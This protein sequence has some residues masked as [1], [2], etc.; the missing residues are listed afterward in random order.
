MAK[1][2]DILK[3]YGIYSSTQ[4]DEDEE[5][6]NSKA[7]SVL[8]KYG[9]DSRPASG[10]DKSAGN[11]ILKKYGLTPIR[12]TGIRNPTP[13]QS[14]RNALIDY[15]IQTDSMNR[16]I[17]Q[18][19]YDPNDNTMRY[20]RNQAKRAPSDVDQYIQALTAA[21]VGSDSPY[22]Q[23]LEAIKQNYANVGSYLDEQYRQTDEYKMLN[24]DLEAGQKEIDRLKQKEAERNSLRSQLNFLQA[25]G[26]SAGSYAA[27][28]GMYTDD[29]RK[30]E[31]ER[32]QGELA[33]YANV[34]TE[35][36]Q[37]QSMKYY[38]ENFRKYN[39]V[40]NRDD[41]SE[42]S[43][44]KP[45]G[46]NG[47]WNQA[48]N[49]SD[50]ATKTYELI[51]NMDDA[52]SSLGN[53]FYSLDQVSGYHYDLMEPEERKMFNYL[54]NTQGK[55]AASE[56]LDYI[57]FELNRRNM[58]NIADQE[59][60]YAQQ[61]FG[62]GLLASI[63]SV[64]NSL[65]GGLGA[66]DVTLQ[67]IQRD[68]TG[69]YKPIDYNT[70]AMVPS[71]KAA[72]ARQ[73]V[74]ESITNATGVIQISEEEHPILA[75]VLNGKS[76]ADVYNLGMS[77]A[78]SAAAAL[79]TKGLGAIGVPQKLASGLGSSLL[80]GNAASQGMIEAI[81]NGA[82]D[83]QALQLGLMNGLYESLFEAVSID[84]LT[85]DTATGFFKTMLKQGGIEASEEA[86]TT[87][88]NTFAD[89]AIM[90]ENSDY[91]KNISAYMEQGMTREEAEKQAFLDSVIQVGW[92]A[93]GG[94]LSGGVSAG[95]KY[96]IGSAIQNIKTNEQNKAFYGD[97]TGSIISDA[98]EL[99]PENKFVQ[100]MQQKQADGKELSGREITRLM[101]ENQKA[102]YN[103]EAGEV[104]AAAVDS[105]N[106]LGETGD[107]EAIA[108]AITKQVT[109]KKL[110]M[111][112]K[113]AIS[114]SQFGSR[115][116]SELS[117]Y[118]FSPTNYYADI[119]ERIANGSLN[120]DN[121]QKAEINQKDA[122][123]V[124]T[125]S[126]NSAQFTMVNPDTVAD[127]S[128]S[129]PGSIQNL[130]Q[131]SDKPVSIDEVAQKYGAQSNYVKK[132]YNIGSN[133]D[134]KQ[135]DSAFERVFNY[136]QSGTVRLDVVKNLESIRS[137]LTDKQIELAYETGTAAANTAAKNLE[138]NNLAQANGKNGRKIGVVKGEGVS[139]EDLKKTFNDNQN[140]A[141][142]I[143]STY[144]EAT[145]IDIVLYQSEMDANGNFQG[146]Q[147]R[148]NRG[149]PGT[150][151]IDINAGL[152]G[153]HDVGNLAK[154]TMLR[155][156]AHEFTHFI[157]KWNPVQY[158]EF[159]KV[160]FDTLRERGENVDDLVEA[161]QAAGLSYDMASREVVAEAMTDIL[162]DSHFVQNLAEKHK[163]IFQK[164]MEKLKEF[165]ESLRSYFDSLGKNR[166]REAN[167]LKEQVGETVRYVENIVKMFD[168]VAEQAVENYQL[169]VAVDE[170]TG[171]I[172]IE[173]KPVAE[174]AE[175]NDT[176]TEDPVVP[177]TQ[178]LESSAAPVA[179]TENTEVKTA[180]RRSSGSKKKT[181]LT[182][183]LQFVKKASDERLRGAYTAQDGK[184]Y[185]TDGSFAAVF[186]SADST[187]DHKVDFP[188]DVVT[189]FFSAA[190]KQQN[191][192]N[193]RIDDSEIRTLNRTATKK[194]M[195][196]V[197]VGPSFF[198]VKYVYA[199]SRAF[200]N[201]V[202]SLYRK[203]NLSSDI[204]I[205]RVSADNGEAILMPVLAPGNTQAAYEAKLSTPHESEP[206]ENLD[207]SPVSQKEDAIDETTAVAQ[208]APETSTADEL[209]ETKV[210]EEYTEPQISNIEKN[211]ATKKSTA[212]HT[213]ETSVKLEDFGEKI[214][215]ARKDSWSGRG[216]ILDDLS[217]MNDRERSNAVKKDNVWRRPDYR[218]LVEGGESKALLFARNEIRKTL[219]QNITYPRVPED[220]K[221]SPQY[222]EKA[223]KLQEDF[224]RTV[225]EIQK[226]A[227][228]AKTAEDFMN[229]GRKWLRENGYITSVGNRDQYTEK[230]RSNPALRGSDYATTVE[231]LSRNFDMLDKL[232]EKKGFAAD[233]KTQVPKGFSI[234]QDSQKNGTWFAAKGRYIIRDNFQTYDDALNFL[235]Q[236]TA[237]KKRKTRFVPNQLL[238]VHRK[239]PD[240]R[241][242]QDVTGQDY[243][244][245]FG[246]RGGEFGNWMSEKDRRVSMNYGF[247]AL[248][249]LADALQIADADI[250]LGGN[251]SIAF[252]SRGQGLSGAAAHYEPDR[253]VINLTKMNGA[254]SLAH[255]WFHALDD[256]V[257][258]YRNNFAT[259]FQRG[260]PE[261]TSQAIRHLITTMQYRDATQAETD[262]EASKRYEQARR[263]V[264]YNITSMF[265]WVEKM[266]AGTLTEGETKYFKKKPTA[267]DA[268][269]FHDALNRLLDSGDAKI[270]EELSDLRKE[271][272]G[273]VIPK[274]IRDSIGYRLY[275]LR[276]DATKNIQRA[277]VFSDFYRNSRKFNE[278][279]QKDGDYWDST[280]EM[281]ARAFACYIADKTGARNDYLSAHSD[282]AVG[283]DVNKSGE[284]TV[285]KA[286]PEGQERIAINA[287]FDSLFAA[288][289]DDG[290]LHRQEDIEKPGVVQYQ[291]RHL[292]GKS[293]Q[294]QRRDY[295]KYSY[296]WFAAK[297]DMPMTVV[298][299]NFPNNH[300]AVVQKAKDNAATIG[301]VNPKDRSV[302]VYVDDIGTNIVLG[303]KGL[304]HGLDR[305]F[306]LLAPITVKAGEIIKNSIL[307]NEITPRDNGAMEGYVLIGIAKASNGQIYIVRSV[308]NR[309][310]NELA[311]MDV[312]YAINAKK[313][314][315]GRLSPQGG[316]HKSSN[317]SGSK[318]SIASLLSIVNQHFP[319]V[320]PEDVLKH[321]G[322]D[323]RPDGTFS[324]D[325]L[326]QQRTSPLTDRDVLEAA[327]ND[328]GISDMSDA[329]QAALQTFK[330][331]LAELH[332]LQEKRA[333]A[334]RLYKEQQ[335]GANVDRQ[336]AAQTLERMRALDDQ[337]KTASVAVLDVEQKSVLQRVL[338]KA[339]KVV[340]QQERDRS[341]AVLKRWRDR[342]DNADAVKKY[343]TRVE[344]SS[345][346]LIDM[347]SHPTKD[348]HVPYELQAPL[349]E[350]L[351][352]IDF[353]SKTQNRG[354]AP[355]I[356]DRAYTSALHSMRLAI[357]GQ[358]TAIEG[359]ENGAYS[360]DV[361]PEFLNVIDEH[362][363]KINQSVKS[364]Q[365]GTSRVYDMTSSELADLA[366]LLGTINK[367]IR[368]ID[369]LHMAGSKA[370]ISELAV[371]TMQEMRS[372]K[373]VKGDS[374]N[375][376]I[377]ANYTPW[378][379]FRAMGKD[380]QQIFKG[381]MQ[382]QAK[383]ARTSH[384]TIAFTEKTYKP[385]EA[386]NW[387][388]KIHTIELSSGE[389]I[390]MTTAQ[391]MSFWCLSNR[392]QGVG[393]LTGGGIRIGTIRDENFR[394]AAQ[395]QRDIVQ[396]EH[397]VLTLDDIAA[398]N[399]LL[400]DRQRTVAR[401]LQQYMQNVGG[402]LGNEISMA[403]WDFMQFTEDGYFPIQT[404][405]AT[406]DVKNPGQDKTN[407]WALLN[408]SFT[409]SLTPNAKNAVI[410]NSIFDVFA[411]HMTEM[412][413][414]NAFALPL[415]DAMKWFNY[416][417]RQ[418]LG[419]GQIADV[420]V[421]KSI[422][423]TLGTAAVKYFVDLMT[424]LNSSQKAGRHENILGQILSRTK[425]ASV[426]W[427]L[428]VAV[429]QPT[430]ILRASMFLSMPDLLK[431]SMRIGAS[432]SVKEMQQYSGIALWKS[433][434]FYDVNV[435]R[436]VREQI[437]GNENILDKF[438]S[439]GM[440]LPGKM[441]EFT[442]ARIWEA[443]K[444]KV[445]R[446]QHFTGEPLLKATAELFEDI[447]Y[448]SQVA[449]S[450]L[451]RSSFMRSKSQ[452]MREATSFMS[453]PTL[454]SNI[455]ISAFQDFEAGHT[456]WDKAKRA[457]VIGFE[458]Y[459]L[460]GVVNAMVTALM[461]AWRDDDKYETF[462][463]KYVQ[464]L[465][466]EN[467][468][469]DGNLFAEM[470]PLEKIIFVRDALSIIRGYDVMPGYADLFKQGYDFLTSAKDFFTDRGSMTLYGLI[471]RGLQVLGTT[472]GIA[473][474]GLSREAIALH[475]NVVLP[476][477]NKTFGQMYP[478]MELSPIRRYEPSGNTEIKNAFLR[479]YLTEEEAIS[480]LV[481]QGLSDT[482]NDAYFL[483][484]GWA[485]EEEDYTRY[486]KVFDA[487]RNNGDFNAALNDMV[488]HGYERD[489]VIR[490][491]R[492]QIGQWYQGGEI[493]K[494]QA[495][496]MLKKHVGLDN[497][498]VTE[499][500]NRWSSYVVTGIKFDDIKQAYLDG[501]ITLNRAI[502]MYALYGSHTKERATEIVSK[503]GSIKE[504]GYEIDE[505]D[506]AYFDGE[507]GLS[508]V[509]SMYIKYGGY[510]AEEA[511]EKT[512]VLEFVKQN[513]ACDGISYAAVSGYN[514][515]CK[516]TGVNP[517]TFYD[518]WKFKNDAGSDY[519]VDGEVTV[520]KKEKVMDYIDGLNLTKSQKDSLYYACG[521]AESTLNETPWH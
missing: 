178:E 292:S 82:T 300:K 338:K 8:E 335:F 74:G 330:D 364:Y 451:T 247:D 494:S 132:I 283:F 205:L 61:N 374:G 304:R 94:F 467:S 57:Q 398:I 504:T 92:D 89:I 383:L 116:A 424:D 459:V 352:S 163:N 140:I 189:S 213:V 473:F 468:I 298:D 203:N 11:D 362:I 108:D 185:L 419:D 358:R 134:V 518:V 521:Y 417:Q 347:L 194:N 204:S 469:L 441:D 235:K 488:N 2:N 162:P 176:E 27:A 207:I 13:E 455:L 484:Q 349:Q 306:S 445:R 168:Q 63:G 273:R 50:Y 463:E 294:E 202:Y 85:K 313:E 197:K 286:F 405:D 377:W 315:A 297:P 466:G 209:V 308:V 366:Y 215:G 506:D 87:I 71:I 211:S 385:E 229:M 316:Q 421:Q 4:K 105:L 36:E 282:S 188:I 28:S 310:A 260:L 474:A 145:G 137:V 279:Y 412:A 7:E 22:L 183:L 249:D 193:Y 360:L 507:V 475:N 240:Y 321:Y 80:G 415:V 267:D 23:S 427:N 32:L 158:N 288:L 192:E 243:L 67:K 154:Y 237:A 449:D 365:A 146:A 389:T 411:D 456:T 446:E 99:S 277:R 359:A 104:R 503:W 350:L 198:N 37:A 75:K 135:F 164:L 155:T 443:T 320:L 295:Q 208:K 345:K 128:E 151:Y 44:Y 264:T 435:S 218:K 98:M 201:P 120:P 490:Q 153:K 174:V 384:D 5:K 439:A 348:S 111:R 408:K 413:E 428:R 148:F 433:M 450:I 363:Q 281:A 517:A 329:E 326:Y 166:S 402:R 317:P 234:H 497:Q 136:A 129:V 378:Y 242:S 175:E 284:L 514:D 239:G 353:T 159:R 272:Y 18:N 191:T 62:T 448:Q 147:G 169:T 291:S 416:R 95:G 371:G 55:E 10:Q 403:R 69:E 230:W 343:R 287:A 25:G 512:T 440:W 110:T 142:K 256:Y 356:R 225:R 344:K 117:A 493:S 324:E 486:S 24:F 212:S 157:E 458:G 480:E 171:G 322:H 426:G 84:N 311:S 244:D 482:E 498:E 312:L 122:P 26:G 45:T 275:A 331:R 508:T 323:R 127:A 394:R 471:Y 29:E 432:Q 259:V 483:V 161:K 461:D 379:A 16:Y 367:A 77:V 436:G 464:A 452:A 376:F 274:E 505:L 499:Q 495:M 325:V 152:N 138:A 14:A 501:E 390:R 35:L 167:A 3:R 368:D 86:M 423:D 271:V 339:R 395:N 221:N 265:S 56:Y 33:P 266:E 20:Y 46:E 346:A 19:P 6:E 476:I 160:V 250:S 375:R 254:G 60:A 186:N 30:A 431:G 261:N 42:N 410:V 372:R 76:L 72:S 15:G 396:K 479:G 38:S 1:S 119:I 380:A 444:A 270:I 252:G 40:Q 269:K 296:E 496:Q 49:F 200:E 290:F 285:I 143:L 502:E 81:A 34:D 118:E 492:T 17:S 83:E 429:Q 336:A 48:F 54:F 91:E 462:W 238:E 301:R 489:T 228:N 113:S 150:I 257:G 472:S 144:A 369:K 97:Y 233:V 491:V 133:Q 263:S 195:V 66:L 425:A 47:W 58:Q 422:R 64:P 41:F 334:G 187:L 454:S 434:G 199:L 124:S 245:T 12:G 409:K 248:K 289:K 392:Q 100:S 114:E 131:S 453:E 303:T 340:E 407:L 515:Y 226:L 400:T 224:I 241:S 109:G 457:L 442:W 305:R 126:E 401:E 438:N 351:D 180:A 470:N 373:P 103:A 181:S 65:A 216:L 520:S 70:N 217:E 170:V 393:H 293:L 262:L 280:V 418:D 278:I 268:Q 59:K 397:F 31:I 115:V 68:I 381:L 93:F 333:E 355:T 327:A 342:R 121:F 307:I 309:F 509:R 165:V 9:L 220:M 173:E 182:S 361:P 219:N 73:A 21:G 481:Q 78:D 210:S 190:H 139:V 332:E 299:M 477:W 382:G 337:I 258:G 43:Q 196:L 387:E 255:E 101:S 53:G 251:L 130:E 510:T 102:T 179:P 500:V 223:K 214:G 123:S 276:P 406:R 184:Q 437:K 388:R 354:G 511:G 253:H 399:G 447:V 391:I 314:P 141:Y 236:L 341:Q 328:I 79:L 96:A 231:Y 149:E 513:P 246:F 487:V 386:K 52:K 516:R 106:D 112:E 357:A 232:A 206:S 125:A 107:V 414:Y 222:L 478:N 404:D 430:A 227:E 39:E 420:G 51:N 460:A 172:T 370:R 519:D 90:A 302:S 177:S 485:S 465:F 318:I 88:A 319:D 156:F